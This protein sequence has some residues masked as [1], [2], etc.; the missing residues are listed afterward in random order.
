ME[1]GCWFEKVVCI[2]Y[3]HRIH[4]Q[5]FLGSESGPTMHQLFELKEVSWKFS[6][7]SVVRD[8]GFHCQGPKF[9]PWLGELRSHKLCGTTEKKKKRERE[10]V[11]ELLCTPVISFKIRNWDFLCGPVVKTLCPH[12]RQHA[13]SPWSGN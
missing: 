12:C 4:S 3:K 8:L 11:S 5:D 1:R 9:N 2:C 13:F 10:K 7:G 6:G